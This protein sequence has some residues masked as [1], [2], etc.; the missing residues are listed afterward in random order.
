MKQINAVNDILKFTI[1]IEPI[2][3]VV[4]LLKNGKYFYSSPLTLYPFPPFRGQGE[5]ML[6]SL[7]LPSS[8]GRMSVG[9]EGGCF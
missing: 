7:F 6:H 8:G 2:A 9:Q 1:Y 4:T 5:S 3:K